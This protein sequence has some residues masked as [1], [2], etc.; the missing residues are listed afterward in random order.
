MKITCDKCNARFKIDDGKIPEEGLSMQCPK[1]QAPLMV[2]KDGAG[3][4]AAQLDADSDMPEEVP[5]PP[6]PDG[7]DEEMAP[8]PPVPDGEDEKMAPPP[9]PEYEFAETDF[10]EDSFEIP[11]VEVPPVPD[12][13]MEGKAEEAD[14]AAEE[15]DIDDFALDEALSDLDEG[16]ELDTQK[17]IPATPGPPE[18]PG[19]ETVDEPIVFD[20]PM[21]DEMSFGLADVPETPEAEAPKEE[22]EGAFLDMPSLLENAATE[23]EKEMGRALDEGEELLIDKP[24]QAKEKFPEEGFSFDD[25]IPPEDSGAASDTIPGIAEAIDGL[26]DP[27][28]VAEGEP[29]ADSDEGEPAE[30]IQ[31]LEIGGKSLFDG[32]PEIEGGD[33][34][35]DMYQVRRASGKIFGP[36]P[37]DTIISMLEGGK[38]Q[39]TEEISLSGGEWRHFKDV[40]IF[41]EAALEAEKLMREIDPALTADSQAAGNIALESERKRLIEESRKRRRAGSLDVVSPMKQRAVRLGSKRI[42]AIAAAF[43]IVLAIVYIEF[44]EE[45]SIFDLVRGESITDKPLIEQLKSRYR[46][47]YDLVMEELDKDNYQ[48]FKK[49]REI[50]LE[51]LKDPDFRGVTVIWALLAQLDYQSLKRFGANVETAKEAKHA[52]EETEKSKREDPE[53]LFARGAKL[54][55]DKDYS[56]AKEALQ[57]AL[58]NRPSDKRALHL[59]AET[60]L[61]LPDKSPAEKSLAKVIASGQATARTYYLQGRLY[62]LLNKPDKA[63]RSFNEALE[64]NPEHLDSQIELAGIMLRKEGGFVKAE[65]ELNTIRNTFKEGLSKKQ[66]ARIHYYSAL[67]HKERNEAYKV[68]KEL[69]AAIKNEPDNY[70]YNE[71]LGGFY[72]EKHELEK[73]QEQFT[74]CIQNNLQEIDCHL[75]LGRTLLL[76]ERPDQALFKMETA[77]K[78]APQ[79]ADVYFIQGMALERLFKP[80]K[81]LALYQKAI[82]LDPNGV[83]YY[84]SA[85]MSYLRQDN[86]TKAGEYIQKA[87]LVDATSPLVHNFLGEMHLHL[88]DLSK[89]EEEFQK[90]IETD[91]SFIEAHYHLAT[92]YRDNKKFEQAIK[93]YEEVLNLDDKSDMA[94]YGLARTYFLMGEVEKA[95]MEYE[96]ALNLN[97]RNYQ[98]YYHTGLAYYSAGKFNKAM[99]AFAKSSDLKPSFALAYFYLGRVFLDKGD[100]DKTVEN[101]EQAIQADPKN[102][103]FFFY[104]GLL[105][106]KQEKYADAIDFYDKALLLKKDYAQAY[107]RKGI[108]LR[109]QNKFKAA[110]KMFRR[111]NKIDTSI[112]TALIELGDCYFEMRLFN[113]A[114]SQFKKAIKVRPDDPEAYSRLGLTYQESGKARKAV[115]YLKKAIEFDEKN[116]KA[117]LGLGYAYKALRRKNEAISKFERY[118]DLNPAAID[119]EDVEDEIYWLKHR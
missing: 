90:A 50:C 68:V 15:F 55:Y 41:A 23:L 114:I 38:L 52:I 110:I 28:L 11:E 10:G 13:A 34:A 7:E 95:I 5:P 118:L 57:Q 89:A 77:Q 100:Y 101:L 30:K 98:Y 86:L 111:A 27:S 80:Q 85:A 70:L 4:S 53:I 73:A 14:S 107:L 48:G 12:E 106:E 115:E 112:N 116:P 54:I 56:R 117:H 35:V 67:I 40:A 42:A 17:S 75:D 51:M 96:K 21:S 71:M 25:M 119:K 109:K 59:I 66:V 19:S 33:D 82:D 62:D 79:N 32:L 88:G 45:I 99:A 37:S 81:A 2:T 1:C 16:L 91:P 69:T 61:Y 94:Y 44:I 87:K 60:Y 26:D 46:K 104:F 49:G 93:Q 63:K 24:A 39:G 43:V 103:E 108:C 92:S 84:T 9:H 36:F 72:L 20:E 31:G 22:E 18:A 97:S 47:N 64:K 58:I 74:L 6:I 83:A 3:G 76:L 113:E 78:I 105:Q 29:L 8:P 65:R 102:Q